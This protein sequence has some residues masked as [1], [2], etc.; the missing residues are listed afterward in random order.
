MVLDRT[1]WLESR[2]KGIGGTDAAAILGVS[3]WRTAM[4]VYQDK[5]GI[6]E[7]RPSTPAMRWGLALEDA[8]ATAYTAETGRK[9]RRTGG[10]R[11]AHHVADFPMIGSID[12]ITALS[13]ESPRI[14]ELKTSRSDQGF[15]SADG[16]PDVPPAERIPAG[17][18]VQVQHYLEV[19]DVG[20]ADLAVLFGG[21]D[22]RIIGI[23]RDRDFGADLRDVEGRFWRDNVLARVEPEV[24]AGDLD[25][26][27]RRYPRSDADEIV[28]TA[29]T[30]IEIDRWLA[31][32]AQVKALLEDRDLSRARIE[33]AMGDA[34][35]LV[36]GSASVSWK[37]HDREVVG[38]KEVAARYRGELQIALF[39]DPGLAER[40][41][42]IVSLYSS[43][44]AVR[45]FRVDRKK[46]S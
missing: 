3:R 14:I 12:R 24:T 22:F 21:S 44:A 33:A 43:V 18:Y 27:A 5:L 31:I 46:E 7:E 20:F 34:G 16:W 19:A 30:S 38:W 37:S 10:I 6:A 45:P 35:R 28:A 39:K 4:D 8:I 32:D 25:F 29:E 11:R 40:L 15:A 23:P 9:V 17:Y 36:S 26:L 41:N 2:R 1:A 42:A 13:G